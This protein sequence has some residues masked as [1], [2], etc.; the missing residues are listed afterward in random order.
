MTKITVQ[1]VV[2]SNAQ[3]A[4]DCYTQPEHIT[5]WNFASD[6]WHCPSASN[7][8]RVGGK[9]NARM[10]AKD[11][12]WGFDFEAIY[13]NIDSG[14]SFT[15]VMGDGRAADVVFE[16]QGNN[17]AV[18]VTFDAEDQNPAEMQKAGWQAILDNYKKYTEAN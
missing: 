2:A 9:Y 11:G 13:S 12:S 3:R 4:W 16:G 10:E 8:L 6:D 14:K 7:D 15:Y 1:T 5:K 17:T 18:T